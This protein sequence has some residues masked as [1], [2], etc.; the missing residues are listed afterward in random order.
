MNKTLLLVL[1]AI[2]FSP[3][4]SG[5]ELTLRVATLGYEDA[6]DGAGDRKETI[7]RS[8]ETQIIPGKNF[9]ASFR[10]SA[11]II[12][13]RGSSAQ[14]KESKLKIS[15][16]YK[17]SK[18]TAEVVE[19]IRLAEGDASKLQR[20]S[21]LLPGS[22]TQ[23]TITLKPG[24]SF[25]LNGFAGVTEGVEKN[26]DPKKFSA[27]RIVVTLVDSDASGQKPAKPSDEPK[28]R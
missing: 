4:V 1:F 16:H 10:N 5:D 19:A 8:I 21:T 2:L 27:N 28:S 20:I 3:T 9:S 6:E 11:E 15:L 26:K 18:V 12:E 7:L 17:H 25:T 23:T 22:S 13:L 14:D 24:D